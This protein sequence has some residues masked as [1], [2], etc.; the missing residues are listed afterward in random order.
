MPTAEKEGTG[1]EAC[2]YCGGLN[3]DTKDYKIDKH[4]KTDEHVK[5]DGDKET[6]SLFGPWNEKVAPTCQEKGYKERICIVPGCYASEDAW[7]AKMDHTDGKDPA[8]SMMVFDH[9]ER[10][11]CQYYAEVWVCS[12]PNCYSKY[13]AK[14]RVWVASTTPSQYVQFRGPAGEIKDNGKVIGTVEE[15]KK[16][17][18]KTVGFSYLDEDAKHNTEYY[19]HHLYTEDWTIGQ[20]AACCVDGFKWRACTDP[21][22]PTLASKDRTKYDQVKDLD[23]CMKYP[24]P[25]LEPIY[26]DKLVIAN[27]EDNGVVYWYHY[28]TC[29][30]PECIAKAE[31]DVNYFKPDFGNDKLPKPIKDKTD[32]GYYTQAN[33]YNKQV[34]VVDH[35]WG[36]WNVEVPVTATQRGHL[37]RTCTVPG[38]GGR[39]DF[40][41]NQAEFDAKYNP[42]HPV[43]TTGII[44]DEDGAFKLY[45][46]GV[47]DKD[48][49]GIYD[50]Y[51]Y[52]LEKSGKWYVVEGIW[53]NDAMGATLVGSTWYFLAN[54]KVQE[55]TQLAEYQGKWFYVVNGVID[56]SKTALVDYNGGKFV[57]ALGRIVDEYS[58]LWQNAKSIGGDDSWYYVAKGQV[59]TQYT[60]L[61][62]YN[63][64]WFYVENGQ[65]VPYNGEVEYDGEIFNVKEGMVV[66]A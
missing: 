65:L 30:R 51:N 18:D 9:I 60:G 49:T 59:Q 54:G 45:K 62:Q 35:T 15:L 17:E 37:F 42:P 22:C 34:L 36:A 3:P 32:P 26:G 33:N 4:L 41:G 21:G 27:E 64:E 28:K 13:D 53:E 46:M 63:G 58:G 29:T 14:N 20:A 50:G 56:T 66:A 7:I 31:G 19:L 23:G 12:N 38:C 57:V 55:V 40:F 61:V 5:K 24:I 10:M 2:I 44:K 6:A 8:E 47:F 48:F 16:L 25:A 52:V 1:H 11:N 39:E 43:L